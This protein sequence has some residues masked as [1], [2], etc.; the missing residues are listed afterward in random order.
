MHP[1]AGEGLYTGEVRQFGQ[2]QSAIAEDDVP[3]IALL[4]IL[5][6]RA[7][8]SLLVLELEP[9][10]FPSLPE[11]TTQAETVH[12]PLEIG[13]D[14]RTRRVLARPVRVWRKGKTVQVRGHITGGARVGVLPP[15]SPDTTAFLHDKE[16][17]DAGI[18]EFLA[19]TD[20]SEARS[21]H[22]NVQNPAAI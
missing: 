2:V 21:H 22:Q 4:A 6:M 10:E 8:D 5:E 3:G 15:G 18:Q 16:V 9:D 7:P 17:G 14:F 12:T 11:V 13:L 1:A 20:A 19:G